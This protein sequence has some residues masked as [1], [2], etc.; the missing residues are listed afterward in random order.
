MLKRLKQVI[1]FGGSTNMRPSTTFTGAGVLGGSGAGS[2]I[3]G[4]GLNY[5]LNSEGGNSNR[6]SGNAGYDNNRGYV[7]IKSGSVPREAKATMYSPRTGESWDTSKYQYDSSSFNWDSYKQSESN[8]VYKAY[9]ELCRLQG[10]TN[11]SIKGIG[12]VNGT[13]IKTGQPLSKRVGLSDIHTKAKCLGNISSIID[14]M[15]DRMG[16]VVNEIYHMEHENPNLYGGGSG[17]IIDDYAA[18]LKEKATTNESSTNDAYDDFGGLFDETP[19][20]TTLATDSTNLDSDNSSG[21]NNTSDSNYYKDES[22]N[23]VITGPILIRTPQGAYVYDP[24]DPNNTTL[25]NQIAIQYIIAEEE[26]QE[27]L[28]DTVTGGKVETTSS[29]STH[30]ASSI[31]SSNIPK[32]PYTGDDRGRVNT[33]PLSQPV[34]AGTIP[35]NLNNNNNNDEAKT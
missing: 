23:I 34:G 1:S 32:S 7:T 6:G 30:K 11:S 27:V 13:N 17:E 20:N 19:T 10:K 26:R 33:K 16:K 28:N 5:D 15:V 31:A 25:D 9:S 29:H 21:T 18:F 22:G 4:P 2:A 12:K 24:N 14:T 3:G 35:S 8:Q